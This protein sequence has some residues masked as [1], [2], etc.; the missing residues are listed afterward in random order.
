M[1]DC[2]LR[3]TSSCNSNPSLSTIMRKIKWSQLQNTLMFVFCHFH[4]LFTRGCS[5]FCLDTKYK[6]FLGCCCY[7]FSIIW[8]FRP[9]KLRFL[10]AYHPSTPSLTLFVIWQICSVSGEIVRGF[11]KKFH[12]WLTLLVTLKN[13]AWLYLFKLDELT[14][15]HSQFVAKNTAINALFSGKI[16]KIWNPAHV[17]HLTNSK[18]DNRYSLNRWRLLQSSRTILQTSTKKQ[19]SVVKIPSFSKKRL[20]ITVT[21]TKS[22]TAP[23]HEMNIQNTVLGCF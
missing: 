17:K 19:T 5:L 13:C 14:I 16:E 3:N 11:G 20:T 2:T 9:C 22:W 18:S 21:C 1:Q 8:L 23:S 12:Y 7:M 6:L 15:L 4:H 10:K